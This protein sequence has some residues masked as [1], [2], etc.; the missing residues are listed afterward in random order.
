MSALKAL[1]V[2]IDPVTGYLL[3]L[4]T[5]SPGALLSLFAQLILGQKARR[6]NVSSSGQGEHLRD[7]LAVSACK[8][9]QRVP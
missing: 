1:K 9:P 2:N 4:S 5:T 8:P 7:P 6:I 3:S